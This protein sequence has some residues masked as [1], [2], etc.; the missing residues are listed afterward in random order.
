MAIK[1][2]SRAKT[3]LLL[4][5]FFP[6]LCCVMMGIHTKRVCSLEM[7]LDFDSHKNLCLSQSH[8]AKSHPGFSSTFSPLLLLTY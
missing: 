8:R 3:M 6:K 5:C 4:W 2:A 7:S 1:A